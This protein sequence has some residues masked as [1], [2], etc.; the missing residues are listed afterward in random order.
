[1]SKYIKNESNVLVLDGVPYSLV[2]EEKITVYCPCHIC[3]LRDN[4]NDGGKP[5]KFVD[6]CIPI[7]EDDRWF[8]KTDWDITDKRI[9]DYFDFNP[10]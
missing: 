6:L 8:F 4:C 1:M 2:R 9:L 5:F 3:D 7:D 10:E